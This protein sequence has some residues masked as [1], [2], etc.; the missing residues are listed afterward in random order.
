MSAIPAGWYPMEGDEHGR[1]RWW[2]GVVWT[3]HTTFGA[4]PTADPSRTGVE[5]HDP[6]SRPSLRS[7]QVSLAPGGD[8]T[9]QTFQPPLPAAAIRALVPEGHGAPPAELW[10]I[11][12]AMT[13]AAL[14]LL[15]PVVRYSGPLLSLTF[16]SNDFGRAIGALVLMVFTMFAALAG[17]FVALAVGLLRASRVAQILTVVVSAFVALF[18]L[19]LSSDANGAA[20][21]GGATAVIVLI[22]IAACV[23][24][25]GRPAVRA[26]FAAD[27]RPL[28]VA[29]AAVANAYF[30]WVLVLDGLLMLIAGVAGARFVAVGLLLF[31]AAA[32]LI[33]TGKPLR[34][35]SRNAR[36]AVLVSYA[37]LALALVIATAADGSPGPGLILPLGAMIAGTIGLT[38]PGSSKRHFGD[39]VD[40]APAT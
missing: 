11:A 29:T 25:L 39:R 1:L 4:A 6:W 36:A 33:A 2:D 26:H 3:S 20:L 21:S 31:C 10:L 15:W 23:G 30:G 5:P 9:R 38:V 18:A 22:C 13:V 28:G 16:G 12:A 35:G 40:P 24:V 7:P 19:L 34:A 37:A 32:A 17:A 27:S 14:L 8:A